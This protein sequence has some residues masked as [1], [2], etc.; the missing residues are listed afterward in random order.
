MN[1]GLVFTSMDDTTHCTEMDRS[2]VLYIINSV[3]TM[4]YARELKSE[5][6]HALLHVHMV[7]GRLLEGESLSKSTVNTSQINDFSTNRGSMLAAI[8]PPLTD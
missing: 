1:A 2:K 7:G 6:I 4:Y 5:H 8:C 3:L